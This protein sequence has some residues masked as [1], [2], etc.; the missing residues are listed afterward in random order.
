MKKISLLF[1]M[2]LAYTVSTTAQSTLPRP[3]NPPQALMG[4]DWI[5]SKPVVWP[6]GTWD[7]NC[8]FMCEPAKDVMGNLVANDYPGVLA[9][10]E[11]M[12]SGETLE[13]TILDEDKVFFSIYTDNDILFVF[14]PDEYEE[15]DEPTTMVP[16]SIYSP[17]TSHFESDFVH[18]EQKTNIVEGIDGLEPFFTW[19]IGMQVHY[20]VDGEIS[21]SDIV[22]LEVFPQL[23][24][25]T[26]VTSTS[27]LADWT[28]T[29]ENTLNFG[30]FKNYD[31][32]V[33]NKA[34]QDT[35]KIADI[36]ANTKPGDFGDIEL[37]GRSY[38]VEN[39][40]PG[41]TY[42]YYVVG[43]HYAGQGG[44][45]SWS[46]TV[47]EVTLPLVDHVYILGEV[48]DKTWAANDGELM[49]YDAVKN[50]YTATVTFDGRNSGYNYFS[51]STELANDNDNGGW[52]YIRPFRFGAVSEG[53]F[54]VTDEQLNKELS[55][56]MNEEPHAFQ[57]PA[58]T[59]DMTVDYAN[60]KL[61]IKKEQPA[62]QIGDVNKDGQVSIADVTE[63]I[64]HLLSD[65]YTESDHFSPVAA[66]VNEDES[67]SIADVTAL[68][69]ILLAM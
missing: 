61:V 7:G 17:G 31:L 52:A 4:Y 27:L 40:T 50:V 10:F 37:P 34:T 20:I 1:V 62:I 46:S 23:K 22:Y 15:F 39:L 3:A 24:P 49:E 47:Q 6:D 54:L 12:D 25:A 41:A 29:D 59:Y 66:N 11:A 68:I 5:D 42:E 9:E 30:G 36:P 55:L 16:Y 18:F 56:E 60:M 14:N 64:D 2:L 8:Q 69:D 48:N 67:I 19:R 53:N 45:A 65:D 58:G 32:Y 43:T 33:I 28:T 63:L 57:I 38:L 21:S 35:I 13:Y 26:E 51:F 44:L